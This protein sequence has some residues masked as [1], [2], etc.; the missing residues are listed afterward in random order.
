MLK[1]QNIRGFRIVLVGTVCSFIE[2]FHI[3]RYKKNNGRD[4]PKFGRPRLLSES[5][6]EALIGGI[7]CLADW[8]FPLQ[9]LKRRWV[10]T[11]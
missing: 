7:L 4:K 9:T 1:R 11:R 8:V 2:T 6:E 3:K 10:I 5:E